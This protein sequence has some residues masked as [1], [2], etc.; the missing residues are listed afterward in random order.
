MWMDVLYMPAGL[1]YISVLKYWVVHRER[2]VWQK[3]C[4]VIKFYTQAFL[5]FFS[6]IK[7]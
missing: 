4:S 5:I 2:M 3:R 7:V 1:K 6:E